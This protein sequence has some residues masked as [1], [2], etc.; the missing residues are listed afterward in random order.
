M[1]YFLGGN[2][3]MSEVQEKH[4]ISMETIV[5]FDLEKLLVTYEKELFQCLLRK[6]YEQCEEVLTNFCLNLT[7]LPEKE[8]LFTARVYFISI[9]THLIRLQTR[10]E[11]LHPQVLTDAYETISTIEEWENISEF[12]LQIP[13]FVER[14]KNDIISDHLL[15][16]GN[17][18][19]EKALQ[20]IHDHLKSDYLNVNW[21]A[22]QLSISTT[23]LSNL[24][25]LHIGVN[26]SDYIAEQKINDIIYHLIHS[27]ESMKTIREKYGFNNHSHFIQFFKKHKGMTPLQFLQEHLHE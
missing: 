6:K 4:P 20:L 23:H 5:L 19:V 22:G 17:P 13:W 10:K 2:D 7:K 3:G 1:N 8:Q 27:N 11:C 16:K 24:F 12:L 18:H 21:L 26:V 25:K 9:I 14:L 15:F